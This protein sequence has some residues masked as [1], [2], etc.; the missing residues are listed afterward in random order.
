MTSVWYG[1]DA[2][3]NLTWVSRPPNNASGVRPIQTFGY[4]SIGSGSVLQY[5][6]SPRYDAGCRAA[7]CGT[8]GGLLTFT[9]TGSSVRHVG[10]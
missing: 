5:A 10:A 1:Y 4:Q 9:F 7:G 6:A 3:G 2:L 8:D